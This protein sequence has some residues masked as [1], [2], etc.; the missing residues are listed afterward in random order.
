MA[1]TI[2]FPLQGC[3]QVSDMLV[4]IMFSLGLMS[5]PAME[6]TCYHSIFAPRGSSTGFWYASV[7]NVFLSGCGVDANSEKH[8]LPLFLLLQEGQAQVS[9]TLVL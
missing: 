4:L 1:V 6:N 2:L 7:D 3:A 5:V 9:D 8:L